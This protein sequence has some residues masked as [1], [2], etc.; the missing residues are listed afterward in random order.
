MLAPAD[1]ELINSPAE[2]EH[3]HFQP[4]AGGEEMEVL[5]VT[6]ILCLHAM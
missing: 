4:L 3:W 6:L 1:L 5:G 2:E